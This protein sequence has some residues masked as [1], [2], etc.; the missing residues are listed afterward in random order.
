MRTYLAVWSIAFV[1]M[2]IV[3]CTVTGDL[4]YKTRD[5][6][7]TKAAAPL[8]DSPSRQGYPRFNTYVLGE[9][10]LGC[11][12]AGCSTLPYSDALR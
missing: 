3:A 12:L 4:K 9:R 7:A 8:G 11:G 6:P 1:L 10:V 5:L 2:S